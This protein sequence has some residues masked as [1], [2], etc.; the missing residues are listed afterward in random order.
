M[1]F[2]SLYKS[3]EG[4]FDSIVPALLRVGLLLVVACG[5]LGWEG[6]RKYAMSFPDSLRPWESL[7][8]NKLSQQSALLKLIPVVVAIAALA[9]T[10]GA[11]RVVMAVG[12]WIPG[13]LSYSEPNVMISTVPSDSLAQVWLQH[14][15]IDGPHTLWLLIDEKAAASFSEHEGSRR[16]RW[17]SHDETYAH[18]DNRIHTVKFMVAY[19]LI[20]ACYALKKRR[21]KNA[22]VKTIGAVLLVAL[23]T[24]AYTIP[25]QIE[26]KRQS[27]WSKVNYVIVQGI[28]NSDPEVKDDSAVE[29]KLAELTKALDRRRESDTEQGIWPFH[30]SLEIR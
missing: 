18:C 4:F 24:A 29:S 1:E 26:S 10:V 2:E 28:L 19:S 5:M 9:V 13:E 22:I 15:E 11:N 30:M 12:D 20:I 17:A 16:S 8:E 7:A 23:A 27:D 14:P 6:F 21:P 25:R 3:V